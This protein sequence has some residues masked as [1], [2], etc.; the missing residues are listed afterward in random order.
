MMASGRPT[1]RIARL[2]ERALSCLK[3][4]LGKAAV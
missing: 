1:L 2:G 3:S 4:T